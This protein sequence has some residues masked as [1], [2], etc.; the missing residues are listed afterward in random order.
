MSHKNV[1]LYCLQWAD[2]SIANAALLSAQMMFD[3]LV[4][5]EKIEEWIS[6]CTTW[7][8][9]CCEIMASGEKVK[10]VVADSGAFIR[11]APLYVR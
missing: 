4:V 9:L 7:L 5:V 8:Q 11:N 1:F 6:H 10:H 3:V 2:I